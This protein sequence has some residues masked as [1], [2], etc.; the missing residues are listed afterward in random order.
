MS[1]TVSQQGWGRR[2]GLAMLLLAIVA[3]LITVLLRRPAAEHAKRTASTPQPARSAP[4]WIYGRREARFTIVEYADLECP[5]CR[6]YFPALRR[7]I[8][9]HPDTN[10]QW[11]HLPL[12]F[13]DPA[14]TEEA[15]VAECAGRTNGNDAFWK[16]VAWIYEHTRGDG[17]GL[18]ANVSM[19]G[20][21]SVLR[22]CIASPEPLAQIRAQVS[23]AAKEQ[24]SATPTLRIL[25]NP[26]GKAITLQGAIE[27]DALSS[28]IDWLTAPPTTA[29]SEAN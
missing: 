24:I 16:T 29:N 6:E 13:H 10:W 28:A 3:G 15:T 18:P 14:A 23:A 12:S 19:P 4:P 8:D 20:T 2:F 25:D 27:E 22:A 5:Y 17:A 21:S 26:S 7:W 11:R 9:A 1:G